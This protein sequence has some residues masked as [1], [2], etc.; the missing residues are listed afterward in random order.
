MLMDTL[1][2]CDLL[3]EM[4][5][6]ELTDFNIKLTQVDKTDKGLKFSFTY[7][8]EKKNHK[9]SFTYN[10]NDEITGWLGTCRLLEVLS[11]QNS[12]ILRHKYVRNLKTSEILIV[13]ENIDDNVNK[14]KEVEFKLDEETVIKLLKDEIDYLSY[15]VKFSDKRAFTVEKSSMFASD[16]IK[17][18]TVIII[19]RLIND[20]VNN[21]GLEGLCK[22]KDILSLSNIVNSLLSKNMASLT[23]LLKPYNI[24]VERYHSDTFINIS[25][26]NV[27][28][29]ED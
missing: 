21:H 19:R 3:D 16:N 5:K 26:T 25:T 18:K 1:N 2:T 10:L 11:S 12:N 27:L 6:E 17:S 8:F 4:F 22:H 7:D 24:S 13:N 23:E 9:T 28:K 14:L 29:I 15:V 20:I